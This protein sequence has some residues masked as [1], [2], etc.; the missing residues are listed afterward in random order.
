[1]SYYCWKCGED[2]SHAKTVV[3]DFHIDVVDVLRWRCECGTTNVRREFHDVKGLLVLGGN[4][5]VGE[6]N[7]ANIQEVIEKYEFDWI[8][9]LGTRGAADLAI[10]FAIMSG[11]RALKLHPSKKD[12]SWQCSFDSFPCY[13][14]AHP[15]FAN[16]RHPV[17][18]M[19]GRDGDFMA[20][21]KR[22]VH[23]LASVA[24]DIVVFDNDLPHP[25]IM[26]DVL[27]DGNYKFDLAHVDRV[28]PVL[29]P[30]RERLIEV[31]Y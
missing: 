12:A 17:Y 4:H 2:E 24:T 16:P 10:D 3:E 13:E 15:E 5:L 25:D 20:P 29:E 7:R 30:K 11:K 1:M 18:A 21:V 8:L 22:T 23:E 27:R 6:L 9:T 19:Y 31:C 28:M 26:Y 14:V